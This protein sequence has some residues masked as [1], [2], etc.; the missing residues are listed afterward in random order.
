[1]LLIY[2]ALVADTMVPLAEAP[3]LAPFRRI[4]YHRRGYGHSPRPEPVRP[5]TLVGHAGTPWACW[6]TTISAPPTSPATRAG[7]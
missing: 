2:G 4:L 7:P 3:A 6:T 1:V 5:V